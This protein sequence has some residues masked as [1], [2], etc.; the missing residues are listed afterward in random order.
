MRETIGIKVRSTLAGECEGGGACEGKPSLDAKIS[1]KRRCRDWTQGRKAPEGGEGGTNGTLGVSLQHH[2][3]SPR[4]PEIYRRGVPGG[5]K[6]EE[7]KTV[8][9]WDPV[10]VAVSKENSRIIF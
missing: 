6:R 8:D 5:Q 1:L 4:E 9:G 7:V 2:F 10:V 3:E